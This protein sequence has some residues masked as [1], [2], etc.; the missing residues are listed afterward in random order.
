MRFN[1]GFALGGC[2]LM[3]HQVDMLG[4]SSSVFASR[5][6]EEIYEDIRHVYTA[7]ARARG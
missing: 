6:V 5:H 4:P 3:S 2:H 1:N 7:K